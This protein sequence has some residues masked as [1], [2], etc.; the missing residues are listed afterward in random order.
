MDDIFITSDSVKEVLKV[1]A[2]FRH[3]FEMKDLGT[4]TKIHGINF[5]R[6]IK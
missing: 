1:K 5:W 6:D 3:E 4:A 2:E